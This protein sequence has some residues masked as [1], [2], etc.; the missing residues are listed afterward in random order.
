MSLLQF[1][2]K[3]NIANENHKFEH[4]T[5]R[6]IQYKTKIVFMNFICAFKNITSLVYEEIIRDEL[7]NC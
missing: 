4:N 3:E 2:N 5:Y 6:Q 7:A 1:A